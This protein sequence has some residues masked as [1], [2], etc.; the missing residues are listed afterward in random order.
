VRSLLEP[1][2]DGAEAFDVV[3]VDFDQVANAIF[4][5]VQAWLLGSVGMWADDRLHSLASD[6]RDDLVGVV[7][8]VCDEGFAL[9]VLP[10]GLRGDRGLVL[11]PWSE[12]DVERTALGVDNSV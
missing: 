4:L 5:A 8:R 11:L 10:D 12:F 7:A 6:F 1:G 3:E 9:G 2:G